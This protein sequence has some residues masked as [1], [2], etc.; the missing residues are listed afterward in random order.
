MRAILV[1]TGVFALVFLVSVGSSRSLARIGGPGH[2]LGGPS[3]AGDLAM[4]SL[5]LLLVV[6]GG[7]VY[8][9]WGSRSWRRRDDE[10]EWVVER[11]PTAWWE[12]LLVLA[13]G[14]LPLT[15]LLAATV[16]L[17][18]RARSGT[19]LTQS[20]PPAPPVTGPLAPGHSR[21]LPLEHGPPGVH[22]W[23]S[24]VAGLLLLTAVA[25]VL[26]RRRLASAGGEGAGE[27]P[28]GEVRAAIEESLEELEREPD[29]RRAV[30]RAYVGME[31]A[32][33]RQGLGR[34]PFEA[35]LEYLARVLVAVRVSRP[36]GERLTAL[37]QRARFSEHAIEPGMKQE[38]IAALA[39]VRD[40]L[41]AADA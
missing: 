13:T 35:P 3:I 31:R 19:G 18:R 7:I 28:A 16:F 24:V 40:E 20:V 9:L 12:K 33:A 39:R 27:F 5:A 2:A 15:G 10:P 8:A 6:M 41:K 32:L 34:R 1:A 14:L 22:W 26:L 29:P 17:I 23:L 37:F 30:I 11:P 21:G 36:A 25:L 4:L 38:A